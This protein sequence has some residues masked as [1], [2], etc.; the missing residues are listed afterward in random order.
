MI[1]DFWFV[2]HLLEEFQCGNLTRIGGGGGGGIVSFVLLCK[3]NYCTLIQIRN[4]FF[5][6]IGREA[7]RT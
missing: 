2:G 7:V 3:I 5:D 6:L 1:F 4:E